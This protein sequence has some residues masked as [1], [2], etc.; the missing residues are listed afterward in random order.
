MSYRD[1][2]T[3]VL[4]LIFQVNKNFGIILI[5]GAL[6]RLKIE[7]LEMKNLENLFLIFS[8][9]FSYNLFLSF[10]IK[11]GRKNSQRAFLAS[12]VTIG[13]Y[14]RSKPKSLNRSAQTDGANCFLSCVII[15]INHYLFLL[16]RPILF[17]YFLSLL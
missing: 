6:L 11:I 9:N 8:Y 3:A 1:P 14:G 2:G 17:R 7:K 12:D 5:S 16:T 4:V 10:Y 15:Q 13:Q